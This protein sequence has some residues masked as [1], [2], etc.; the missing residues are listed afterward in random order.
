MENNNIILDVL[1][2]L[3]IKTVENKIRWAS[4]NV[5]A[6]RWT[7]QEGQISTIVT[8]QKQ[9]SPNIVIKEN[10]ILTIQPSN[11][12]ESTQINSAVDMSLKDILSK[13]FLAATSESARIANE[14]QA[15]VIKNLLNGL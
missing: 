10:Y 9:P 11:S 1:N 15:E 8:L 5:N 4:I 6:F 7:K 13:L 2:Q 3:L 12:N 14:K